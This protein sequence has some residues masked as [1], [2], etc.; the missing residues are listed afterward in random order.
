MITIQLRL[1]KGGGGDCE[2][3]LKGRRPDGSRVDGAPFSWIIRH[4]CEPSLCADEHSIA[5]E[6]DEVVSMCVVAHR[7]RSLVKPSSGARTAFQSWRVN[8]AD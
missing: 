7:R 5:A 3:V 8:G 6:L 1:A 4:R 2:T